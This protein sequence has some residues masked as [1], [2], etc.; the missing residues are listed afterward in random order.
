MRWQPKWERLK[1]AILR[2]AR[3]SDAWL[4][5]WSQ[6][7]PIARIFGTNITKRKPGDGRP[8][9]QKA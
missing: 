9:A 5:A 4:Q 1:A 3:K 8:R 6:K 7:A 2:H